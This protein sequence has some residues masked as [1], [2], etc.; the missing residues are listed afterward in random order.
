MRTLAEKLEGQL[1]ATIQMDDGDV[2]DVRALLPTLERRVG[3]ILVNGY[4]DRRR[5]L[6]RH[7]AWRPLPPPP[8]TAAARPW[9][10]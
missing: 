10:A 4:P 8:R 5:G 9:A 7:G 6:P 3:R 1:T 2:A